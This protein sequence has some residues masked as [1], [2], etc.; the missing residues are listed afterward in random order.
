MTRTS[1][2]PALLLTMRDIADLARVQRPVVTMWASRFRGGDRPFPRPVSW[3]GRTPRFDAEEVAE[4]VRSRSLGNSDSFAQDMAVLAVFE[5]ATELGPT[6]VADGVT[7]LLCLKALL[8]E[9]LSEWCADD[10]VDEAE[11][12]DPDDEFLFSEVQALGEHLGAVAAH[13]D[14]MSDAAFTPAHAFETVMSRRFRRQWSALSDTTLVDTTL[15]SGARDLVA[16]VAVSLAAGERPLFVDPSPENVDLL[17]ALQGA[18]PEDHGAVVMTA[19][20]STSGARRARRRLATHRMTRIAPPD[21]GFRGEFSLDRP[22][23]FVTQFPSPATVDY[24]DADVLGAIDNVAVQM[25]PGQR[26]VLIGPAAVLVD[27]LRDRECEAIRSGL[28]RSGHLRAAIRLP[29]GLLPTRPGTSM[30]LWVLGEADE[31]GP[32]VPRHMMLAD[33]GA[34]ALTDD[35][36]DGV[37]ADVAA[38]MGSARE[39]QAHA[40]RF[41]FARRTSEV[42]AASGALTT[43]PRVHRLRQDPAEAAARVL[44]L[45]GASDVAAA[46]I[47][48][49][50]DLRVSYRDPG[51]RRVPTVGD[52]VDGKDLKLVS[53]N[54]IDGDDV[55]PGGTVPVIG[56]DEVSGR[57]AVGRRGIDRLTLTAKYPSGR[58]TESG[59]VVFCAGPGGGALVDHAGASVVQWPA[60]ILRITDPQVSGLCADVL[61]HQLRSNGGTGKPPGAIRGGVGWRACPMPRVDPADLP[62]VDA[63]LGDLR[64]RRAAAQAL[65]DALDD[66]TITLVDG[67]AHGALTVTSAPKTVTEKG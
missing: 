3:D 64:A 31:S 21:G 27:R 51:D 6:V 39:V 47:G 20:S 22:A 4:W 61:A 9:Q 16:R 59:D 1:T 62:A 36:I 45:V 54:R 65:L 25:G 14:R 18:L 58:Y 2:S 41:G 56:A 53:G 46:R 7:A 13:V 50:P 40:F 52:L 5:Q 28:L 29:E 44:E 11:E 23:M 34:V 37:V 10:L 15:A 38:A 30:A 66:L 67:V 19:A 43:L 48:A 49:G 60:R 42:V 35:T 55:V 24:T 63:A 32:E 12:V 8:G 17:V 26:G 57:A 33:L